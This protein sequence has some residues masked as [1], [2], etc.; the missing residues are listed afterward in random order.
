M[1]KQKSS[2]GDGAILP[3]DLLGPLSSE[4][5]AWL[6]ANSPPLRQ[7]AVRSGG[8]SRIDELNKLLLQRAARP[9]SGSCQQIE[10]DGSLLFVVLEPVRS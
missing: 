5:Q 6:V 9:N 1:A 8:Q 3:P 4:N 2:V 7:Q 10:P